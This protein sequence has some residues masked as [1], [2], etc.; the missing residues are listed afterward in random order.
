M[1]RARPIPWT[2]IAIVLATIGACVYDALLPLGTGA[3]LAFVVAAVLAVRLP[4]ERASLAVAAICT[5]LVV[6][7]TFVFPEAIEP[8][9][10]YIFGRALSVFV[11][12]M[13]TLLGVERRRAEARL[14]ESLRDLQDSFWHLR[15]IQEV[16]PLCMSCGKVK[17]DG[18]RWEKLTDFL[19]RNSLL[20]SHGYCPE[21]FEKARR[22]FG[23]EEAPAAER[24]AP[25][26][27]A[28]DSAAPPSGPPG[29]GEPLSRGA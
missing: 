5:A 25:R 21:C 8:P 2:W 11:I 27:P 14:A 26:P 15:K 17:A 23:L 3:S 6:A 28:P 7:F 22:A 18:D 12:W 20:V 13:V 19:R 16:L 4:G 1:P 9:I 29:E 24:T 10:V